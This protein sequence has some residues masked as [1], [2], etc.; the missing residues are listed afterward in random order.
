MKEL[1]TPK[2]VAQAIGVSEASLKRWCDRGLVPSVRTAGGHRR[3][4]VS[5]V[6]QYLRSRGHPL[7]RPE[8]LGLPSNTGRGDAVLTRARPAMVAALRTGDEEQ[9]RRLVFDLYLARV[10][11]RDICDEAIAGAFH[12]VG[13]HWHHGD[14]EVYEERRGCEIAMRVIHELRS[15]LSPVRADAPW[16]I[17]GTFEDD[18]Y[19]LPTAMV[20]L[21]LREAGWR[22][23]TLGIGHP[24]AT[25]CAAL[26]NI[27]PRLFWLSVSTFAAEEVFLE[28]FAAVSE[29]ARELGV[30][31][32]V[33]GRALTEALRS[34]M[35]H[36]VFCDRLHHVVSF[37][38]TLV[39]TT[40][41]P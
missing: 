35:E 19:T 16:A 15:A 10:A 23:E 12:D 2:Q 34:R 3:L 18:P 32:A 1:L 33:G 31:V 5:G 14:M 37:A 24:V 8:I 29:A 20:D 26:R 36:A 17:G 40:E 22:A 25:L 38:G 9:F 27:R 6:I 7:V 11:A 4:P 21:V 30:A 41:A 13:A 28:R 39:S